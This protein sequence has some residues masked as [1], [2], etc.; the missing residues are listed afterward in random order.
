MKP[1]NAD[2]PGCDPISSNCVIWQGPDIACI[3]LCKGD[4]VSN[5]VYKLGLELCKVLETLDIETYDI[6]CLL[7][8]GC[9]PEDFQALIQLLI[10][11]ICALEAAQ[12][13]GGGDPSNPSSG[14]PSGIPI[15]ARIYAGN[16]IPDTILAFNKEFQY[17]NAQGDTVD[18]GQAVD[19]IYTAASKI[20]TIVGRLN[21]VDA[22]LVNHNNRITELE[23][24]FPIP[25]APL[26]TINPICVLAG[27]QSL[28]TVVIELEKGF[29]ELQSATG[30]PQDL[31]NSIVAQC[32]GLNGS[33]RLEG[34]GTMDGIAGWNNAVTNLAGTINNI[35]LSY[36]DARAAILSLKNIVQ[37]TSCDALIITLQGTLTD[38]NTLKIFLSGTYPGGF[39]ETNPLGSPTTITDSSGN[40]LTLNIPI[41]ANLN[42]PAGYTVN[43]AVTPVNGNSNLIITMPIS[44]TDGD[45]VCSNVL[46]EVVISTENCPT[47]S[48]VPTQTTIAW[49]FTY[50]GGAASIDVVL[51]DGTGTIQINNQVSVVTGATTLNGIFSGLIGGIQYKVRLEIT[52]SGAPE[53]TLCPF[54]NIATLTPSCLP[55]LNSTANLTIP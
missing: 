36:C 9:G 12:A 53:E 4:T 42:D 51:Y 17:V 43:L 10:D 40:S 34:S 8:G 49:S 2:T 11:K 26:P 41:V 33:A 35:W 24:Q 15:N 27:P 21:T 38:P 45:S 22:A 6:S 29:C 47:V 37:S 46:T 25:S 18:R 5:V 50:L 30:S 32:A 48:L 7:I 19:L 54:G 44:F 23:D 52:P 39:Q 3:G 16:N 20:Q 13:L 28:G 55:P 31:Y 1:L 14:V